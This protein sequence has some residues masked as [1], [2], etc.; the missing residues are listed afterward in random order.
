MKRTTLLL[1][2]SFIT[3]NNFWAQQNPVSGGAFGT[4]D[5]IGCGPL[6]VDFIATY[7]NGMSYTW[8]FG[9]GNTSTQQNPTELYTSIG[10]YTIS[11]DVLF[12]NGTTEHYIKSNYIEVTPR[13]IIDISLNS[14]VP[15]LHTNSLSFQNNTTNATQYLWD[16]GD[17]SLSSDTAPNHQYNSTGTYNITL[18]ATGAYGCYSDSTISNVV[19]HP[20]VQNSAQINGSAIVCDSSNVFTFDAFPAGLNSYYWELSDGTQLNGPTIQHTFNTYG[21]FDLLLITT[22]TNGCKDSTTMLDIVE[23]SYISDDFTTS[24]TSACELTDIIFN[25]SANGATSVIWDFGDGSSATGFSTSHS[26]QTTGHYDITMTTTRPNGCG[27]TIGRPNYLEILSPPNMTLNLSDSIVCVGESI[28]FD[29]VTTNAQNTTWFFGDGGSASQQITA[30]DYANSGQYV[31]ELIYGTGGCYDTISR[32]ITVNQ[33]TADYQNISFANCGPANIQFQSISTNAVNWDWTFGNGVVSSN[34]NPMVTFNNPGQYSAQLIVED[35]NG[36]FDTTYSNNAVMVSSSTPPNF[37]SASFEGCSPLAISFYNYSV[38]VG[39]WN[40]NFGDGQVS[41]GAT[42]SHTYYAPGEYIVSLNTMGSLGCNI[43]IDTF[44]IVTVNSLIIDSISLNLNCDSLQVDFSIN[45]ADCVTGNWSF[46]DGSYSS[47]DTVTHQYGVLGPYDVNYFGTS[48]LGCTGSRLFRIDFD[49]CAY[50]QTFQGTGSGGISGWN[51]SA[52]STSIGE[53]AHQYCNPVTINMENPMPYAQSWIWHFGDGS[54]GTGLQP[55][56][57]Y[58]SIG[59]YS[60]MLEYFN[61]TIYDTIYYNNF[62]NVTGHT[63]SILVNSRDFCSNL[64]LTI[65]SQD[66][67]LNAYYWSIDNNILPTNSP[68]IDTVFPNNNQLHSITLTT[69]DSNN[70]SYSTSVGIISNGIDPLFYFDATLCVGDSLIIQ[71]DIPSNYLLEWNFGVSTATS[72]NPYYVYTN[73]GNYTINLVATDSSGCELTFN[74][75]QVQ[76]S[77]SESNFNMTSSNHL[78]VGDTV[79]A[80]ATDPTC[81][82]YNWSFTNTSMNANNFNASGTVQSAG[83]H[84]I[85]LETITN[86]CSSSTTQNAIY[87][88]NQAQADFSFYQD[89]LCLPVVAQFTDLSVTPISWNWDFGDGTS[90]QLQHPNHTYLTDTLTPISLTITDINGCM[91]SVTK[92]NIDLFAAQVTVSANNGCAPAAITFSENSQNAVQWNWSFGD[93]TTDTVQ[94]PVH[95]YNLDGTYD[96][97]LIVTSADGCTDTVVLPALIHIDKVVADF[98]SNVSGGCAPQPAYFTDNSYN[99]VAWFWDLGNG[100]VSTQQNPIQ[101]YYTGGNY[102]IELIV[103]SSTGCTDTVFSSTPLSIMGPNTDFSIVDSTICFG[104]SIYFI[105]NSQNANSYT[106][107]FGNGNSSNN[108]APVTEYASSGTYNITLIA[109]DVNG[110]QQIKTQPHQIIIDPIPDASFSISDTIGCNPLSVFL[111]ASNAGMSYTWELNNNITST[112]STYNLTLPIG[113]HTIS[114]VAQTQN[115][116]IDSSAI[117]SIEVHP[118]YIPQITLLSPVCETQDTVAV[119]TSLTMGN[120]FIDGVQNPNN[121]FDVSNLTPGDFTITQEIDTYCGGIDSVTLHVDS[122]IS[123]IMP[124]S[125]IVC[126]YDNSFTL[127][128]LHSQGYWSG[129]GVINPFTGV[130]DPG[131]ANHGQNTLSYTIINGSCLFM[132]SIELTVHKQPNAAFSIINQ[133]LC[134]GSQIHVSHPESTTNT[135][136]DWSFISDFDT[137]YSNLSNP[138]T[139]LESGLWEVFLEVSNLG[140]I[141][142]SSLSNIK[143]YDTLAPHSPTIIRSTVYENE[144]VL[145]EWKEPNYGIE[146]ILDFQIWRSTDSINFSFLTTVP[147]SDLSYIDYN[148]SIDLQNYYYQIVPTNVC[149][150]DPENTRMSSSILLEKEAIDDDYLKLK[151]TKY[152]QWEDGVEYYLIQKQNKFGQWETIKTIDGD[153]NSTLIERP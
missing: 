29:A 18:F 65:S 125:Q 90:S 75:G 63:N 105:N 95:I 140:C 9:N 2:L 83:T 144:A 112:G 16:F 106:W 142:T 110:C 49:S 89:N 27:Q 57:T 138:L 111:S 44:A 62:I 20:S 114:L 26:Y 143:V 30:H 61:G 4:N 55:N 100:T 129:A 135:L 104:D 141:N 1:I 134:E 99:A 71:H 8:D 24:S 78:C 151:W 6:V 85:T 80:V 52:A 34:E 101:V 67:L 120:W 36:C 132:D 43:Q 94:A 126:E 69:L 47:L 37:Q 136:Y 15:C 117:S 35:I 46:G 147:N 3:V 33:P 60:L 32:L 81:D 10:T 88:V 86:G 66:S 137:V 48:N 53:P 72:S 58:D 152:Y 68:S 17:G 127:G 121:L 84:D 11:L 119:N 64:N 73:Q 93:G 23:A 108:F 124:L 21:S 102:P 42:P 128:T 59:V 70:C 25:A 39:Y 91:A 74:L 149:N 50:S 22:D 54:T 123:A 40:W 130:V 77:T 19:I 116:C 45:C 41:T 28:A 87:V 133:V 113:V 109:N 38:G 31:T 96:V 145:T 131:S 92:N 146:K 103:E 139:T 56:H 98:L 82:I 51:P 150:V 118:V 12:Q 97:S 13:P 5:S 122:L 14:I 148:T 7:P 153:S 79:F 107:L 115:G 76:I